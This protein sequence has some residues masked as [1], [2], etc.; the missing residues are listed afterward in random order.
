MTISCRLRLAILRAPIVF[1]CLSILIICGPIARGQGNDYGATP[2]ALSP[3]SPAGSYPL[4]DIDTVNLFNGHVNI[5]IPLLAEGGRGDAKSAAYFN[6]NTPAQ[7]H[8]R[9]EVNPNEAPSLMYYAEQT[10]GFA[11]GLTNGIN[12]GAFTV[13]GIQSGAGEHYCDPGG[14]KYGGT[15]T[16]LYFVEPNGTEHEM[17]DTATDGSPFQA[18]YCP[19]NG[20]SRGRIFVSSDGSGATFIADEV[21]RD[22]V[23]AGNGYPYIG[24]AGYLMLKNGSRYR[25]D[26][27]S[28]SLRDRNG[29]LL[30]WA[31]LGEGANSH[32]QTTD[33]LNRQVTAETVYGSQCTALGNGAADACAKISYKG[34]GGAQRTMWLSYDS[35]YINPLQLFLPNGLS[36]HFYYNDY[37]DLTRIDL[38][39]GGS[40]EYDYGPGLA[41]SQPSYPIVQ[42]AIPGTY[43]GDSYTCASYYIYRR[44]VERR[45]YN[46]GHVLESRQ[47]FSKPET[48]QSNDAGNPVDAGYVEKKQYDG[49][50]SD[51]K[52]LGSEKHYFYGAASPSFHK[53]SSWKDGREY[54]TEIYDQNGNLQRQSDQAWEQR[55]NVAWWLAGGGNVDTE[56]QKDPR[57]SAT[58]LHLEN[59]LTTTTT[60]FYDPTVPYNSLTDVYEYDYGGSA[61]ARHTQTTYLKNLNG[62]DYTGSNITDPSAPY[63]RDFPLQSSVLDAGGVEHARTTFE[64]DN[65]ASDTNYAGL[66][67][68]SGISGHDS[69]FAT[70]YSKRGNVTATTTYLLDNG[71]VTGSVTAYAQYDI[72]GNPVKMIDARGYATTISYDDCFGS[73]DSSEAHINSAPAELSGVG[74][75]SFAFPTAVTNAKNQTTYTK[76]DFY[77][78]KPAVG[79]DANGIV[80]S[81]YYSDSLERPTQVRRAVGT[82]SASQTSFSYNDTGRIVTVTSDQNTFNDNVLKSQT[83][84]DGLGRTI[85]SRQY[86]N[87][88][89]YIAVQQIPFV[90]LQD[91]DTGV[92]STASQSSNPYR[93]YL[94]ETP[95]WTTSFADALGRMTKVRTPDN[96]IVRTSYSANTV[97]V[98][99]Q[100]GKS[101]KS[102]TDA[103]GRL[104]EIREDVNSGGL[105]YLTNYDY[106]VLGDLTLVTQQDPVTQYTQTRTFTYDSLKR[107]TSA[108]NPESG[109]FNYQYDNN[110]NLLVKSHNARAVHA[111]YEYDELNRISR[112]WYNSSSLLSSTT[113][114]S[115]ALPSGIG[116][117]D[118]VKY[119]YDAQNPPGAPSFDRGFATGR[120]IAVTYGGG[121]SGNYYGYDELGKPKRTIQQTGGVNYLT[122]ATYNLA[123]EVLSETYPSQHTVSY[124]YD[125]AGRTNS[126]S[127]SLGDNA[128]RTYSTDIVYSPFGMAKEEFGT[129]MPV[130][131]KQ[132]YNIRG[133]LAEIRAG[134]TYNDANDSSWNRGAIINHYSNGYGCWGASCSAADNNGNLMRQDHWIPKEDVPQPAVYDLVAQQFDYDSLNRLQDVHEGTSW[135]QQYSYDRFGNRKID[136]ANTTTGIPKPD[137]GVDVATNRLTA[138][139]GST[140]SYDEVGNLTNDTY[141]GQGQRIYDAENRM[142]QAQGGAGAAWQYY[143][144]DGEGKRIRRN[145]NGTETWQ[146]YGLG[147]ELVAEYSS[148]SP[149]SVQKEYGYRNGQL[150][151]T[152][153]LG[154]AGW[155][156]AP[157]FDDNPLNPN[158]PGETTVQARHITQLRTAINSVRT[159][160]GLA[161][162]SWQ[163]SA[164]T[165]DLISA[166]PVLEMR[167]ALD[168]AL[169]TPPSPGYAAGL[170]QYQPI[171]AIHVQE[172]RGRVLAAWNS[173]TTGTDIRWL[174]ADQLGTPR[175]ILDQ[176]GSLA[177]TTRHDYLPFGEELTVGGRTTANGYTNS[178]ST[179]QK[180]TGYEHDG[181]TG[182]DYAHARY[183]ANAQG[184]FTGVDPISGQLG[185]PQS[186]NGY[187]YVGNNPVNTTDPT[188]MFANAEYARDPNRDQDESFSWGNDNDNALAAYNWRLQNTLDSMAADRAAN[189]GD[190]DN[191][192]EQSDSDSLTVSATVYFWAPNGNSAEIALGKADAGH[193]SVMFSD[194][195]YISFWPERSPGIIGLA[196]DGGDQP[197]LLQQ[198]L[199]QDVRSES[200]RK[201]GDSFTVNSLDRGAVHAFY[202]ELQRNPGRW[203]A[204]RNCADIVAQALEAGG[205]RVT[206]TQ[207][208]SST[209]REVLG[210][211]RGAAPNGRFCPERISWQGQSHPMRV[212]K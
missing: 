9:S 121:S 141:T 42:G 202:A 47:T 71:S 178:D 66:I 87:S 102:V 83:L 180:F 181:E 190:T 93:P 119:F 162:Y 97:T 101:R 158:Y 124:G 105:N 89:Q 188:G 48:F 98:T 60:N 182:L 187:A 170:A 211:I 165:N 58:S 186:F 133:Q 197:G 191:S 174:I 210:I 19:N 131:N 155:G 99:D 35:T 65:Y 81:G 92:W 123:G 24:P 30:S 192:S 56:P 38:P 173:G 3:G 79:E 90:V 147:G 20:G 167:T 189:R 108:I 149:S 46:A 21:V 136:Q 22:D 127:G 57:I 171:K 184:R 53:N 88:T 135:R 204:G 69:A 6:W 175:I 143:V 34:F 15:L 82:A 164:T 1:S 198:T 91:P 27:S 76:F 14:Y 114:N 140:M 59:G 104:R 50:L 85:E 74:Q 13:Y 54:H 110:G 199:Q 94:N 168:Q 195:L 207:H 75:A 177:T 95:V 142:T 132:F 12:L 122:W 72:A 32:W 61:P 17:R 44:L 7:W 109:T 112:R 200:N 31:L 41:G 4:S 166:N 138:P 115:P 151:V 160:L 205:L 203:S 70:Y 37:G 183:Y 40:I 125:G 51:P 29:N 157:V 120:L 150:L 52:L 169:G 16:R 209:P 176:S 84:Y 73:P 145:V 26:A 23:Y 144:Y 11:T 10:G 113:Q 156:A 28:S 64:Y 163:Y 86:E 206:N 8:V 152:V 78:G 161:A 62:V 159:H 49:N 55:A 39:T 153:S 134:T 130:Y 100:A 63:L 129:T 148:T 67:D 193:M 18:G 25:I 139:S 111:H 185:N 45:V 2:L 146:V 117:S 36:Y 201:P 126:F 154:T 116:T 77:L 118:E 103:L 80:A 128:P 5:Q 96:A 107:L 172:L 194:G 179:R 33:A 196:I 208:G 43:C 106:D 212:P 137:F 68:R